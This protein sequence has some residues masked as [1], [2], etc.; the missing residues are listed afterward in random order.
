ML[1]RQRQA[2]RHARRRDARPHAQRHRIADEVR[3]AVADAHVERAIDEGAAAHDRDLAVP[4]DLDRRRRVV[5]ERDRHAQRHAVE[6]ERDVDVGDRRHEA[7]GNDVIGGVAAIG[8]DG[9]GDGDLEAARTR[10]GPQRGGGVGRRSGRGGRWRCGR[11]RRRRGRTACR[12]GRRRNVVGPTRRDVEG[13][14]A[15]R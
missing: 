4:R 14:A 11:G 6:R 12:A 8:R 1:G 7:A 3:R 13:Q 9:A 5:V 10:C 15:A 2:A